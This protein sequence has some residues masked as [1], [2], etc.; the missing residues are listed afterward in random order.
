MYGYKE[1]NTELWLVA[2]LCCGCGVVFCVM[3][4]IVGIFPTW[5]WTQHQQF[6]TGGIAFPVTF[7]STAI[8][9]HIATND[10]AETGWCWTLGIFSAILWLALM[11]LVA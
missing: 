2:F 3:A 5:E 10:R 11:L 7:F 4:L 1:D 6:V 9:M 8:M